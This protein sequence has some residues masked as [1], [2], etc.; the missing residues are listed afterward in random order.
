MEHEAETISRLSR[1][2][3]VACPIFQAKVCVETLCKY[4]DNILENPTEEKF[5]KIR[6]TNK[7]YLER[8]AGIEGHDLFIQALGFET[9]AI[10]G[11]V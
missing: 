5:R 4:M 11:Q 8:V 7:A 9:Q 3:V 6:K 10:D 1:F 2:H